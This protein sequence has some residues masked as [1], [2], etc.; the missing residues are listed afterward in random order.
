MEP[1]PESDPTISDLTLQLL[2]QD[3]YAYYGAIDFLSKNDDSYH[4]E[5]LKSKLNEVSYTAWCSNHPLA[6]S[7]LVGK[8]NQYALDKGHSVG[9]YYGSSIPL[10][11]NEDFA[12]I[13]LDKM[14]EC[15]GDMFH[16]DY[17]GA[18]IMENFDEGH[19]FYRTNNEKFVKYVKEF[20]KNQS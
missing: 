14:I 9:S 4:K 16:K 20:Y 7:R 1:E 6:L 13:L 19:N 11:L 3:A 10:G 8:M 2:E 5:A 17:Y 12:I 18:S 15:G